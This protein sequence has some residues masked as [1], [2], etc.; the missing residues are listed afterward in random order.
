LRRGTGAERDRSAALEQEH[1][2]H[3]NHYLHYLY[4]STER[5]VAS[6]QGK[7]V[8]A[9][10]TNNHWALATSFLPAVRE[11]KPQP[12]D[13]SDQEDEWRQHEPSPE[14]FTEVR[15]PILWYDKSARC[16]ANS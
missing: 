8:S 6:W 16:N 4:Y 2:N 5:F 9:V 15:R 7:A 11:T 3:T 14:N 10:I 12:H 13:N 1:L